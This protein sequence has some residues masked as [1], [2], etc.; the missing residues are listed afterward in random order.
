LTPTG[1]TQTTSNPAPVD[2]SGGA[3]ALGVN[4]GFARAVAPSTRLFAVGAGV[5]GGPHVKAYRMDGTVAFEFFAYAAGFFGG[6]AVAS[7]DV[8]G[9]GIDDVVTVPASG[10]GPHVKIY[11]GADGRLVREFF[12]YSGFFGGLSVALGDVDADGKLDVITAPATVG[13]PHVKVFGGADGRLLNEFFAYDGRFT[14][15]MTLAAADFDGDGKADVV[16]GAGPSGGSLV[17]VFRG[18]D[19]RGPAY[20]EFAAFAPSFTGGV[21]VAAGDVD[22]DSRPELVAA[23]GALGGPHVQAFNVAGTTPVV[24][25]SFFAQDAGFIGGVRVTMRDLDGDGRSD[26]VTAMANYQFDNVVRRQVRQFDSTGAL[27][28]EFDPFPGFRGGIFV[29]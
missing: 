25:R 12:A 23:A 7:G 9:D 1:F 14:N 11:S 8:T 15:G 17:K 24:V 29:G 22:G 4:F 16:T 27:V 19:L 28:R 2:L 21:S 18:S 6:V 26:F 10:G 3:T 13:G 20:R 5:G